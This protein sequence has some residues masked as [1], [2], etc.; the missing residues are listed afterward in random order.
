VYDANP[1]GS[2]ASQPF[3]SQVAKG[4][5]NVVFAPDGL[6]AVIS[7]SSYQTSAP[8]SQ[9][10]LV[11]T[12]GSSKLIGGQLSAWRG[13]SAAFVMFI[14]ASGALLYDISIGQT[15]PLEFISNFYLWGN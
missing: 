6:H 3:G 5:V 12:G 9:L 15:T 8:T 13:D 11:T 1:D 4:L 7:G 14:D 10:K 2:S